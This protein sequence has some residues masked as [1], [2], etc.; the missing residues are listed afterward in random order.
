MCNHLIACA[1]TPRERKDAV[2]LLRTAPYPYS[3]WAM[4]ALSGPCVEANGGKS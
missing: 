4:L 3:L 1:V 2:E